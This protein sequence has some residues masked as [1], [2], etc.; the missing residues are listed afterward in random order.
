MAPESRISALVILNGSPIS[1][2]LLDIAWPKLV[3]P[4][5][6]PVI[7]ADGAANLLHALDPSRLP[8]H[9][10]GDFDSADPAVLE[11]YRSNGV[12]ILSRPSPLA[13]D[14]TKAMDEATLVRT[15]LD[16]PIVAL[17]GCLAPS[18]LDQLFGNIQEL[19]SR[20][21]SNVPVWWLCHGSACLV[22]N[23]GTHY[24]RV[25]AS[26]E[27]P[28]CGLVPIAGPVTNLSTTGLKWNL[29]NQESRFGIGGLI[30]SSNEVVEAAV[31]IES[32]GLVLWTCEFRVT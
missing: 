16:A 15:P 13:C 32:S 11:F 14:F 28:M 26:R 5:K 2:A 10:V 25:D 24:I 22:L 31:R 6:C 4:E 20:A 29:S 7:C 17:G 8:T 21:E 9:V 3:D 27:G 18:R 12:R 1:A 23:R 30:S 19:C